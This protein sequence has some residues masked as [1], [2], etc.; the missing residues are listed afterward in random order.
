MPYKA[1]SPKVA[2]T[3]FKVSRKAY[4]EIMAK[5]RND[6]WLPSSDT[7]GIDPRRAYRDP[8]K[9]HFY[10]M[11]KD[12]DEIVQAI[13]FLGP[14]DRGCRTPG[15]SATTLIKAYLTLATLKLIP[16]GIY[17]QHDAAN[18]TSWVAGN[19]YALLGEYANQVYLKRD[20]STLVA[21][22][23]TEGISEAYSPGIWQKHVTIYP[24]EIV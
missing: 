6:T 18:F 11:G 10:L 5:P 15:Y 1:L 19:C 4:E 21:A 24:V 13:V 14:Q 3:P 17:F 9:A 20:G 22:K 16:A 12:A 23:I 2:D 8:T 7:E